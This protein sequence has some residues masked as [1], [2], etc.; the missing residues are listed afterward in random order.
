MSLPPRADRRLPVLEIGAGP[1]GPR[2]VVP[3]GYDDTQ[4][5]RWGFRQRRHG[6]HRKHPL[7]RREGK[8]IA[9]PFQYEDYQLEE[10]VLS[11]QSTL[12]GK[13]FPS[14]SHLPRSQKAVHLLPHP[15]EVHRFRQTGIGARFEQC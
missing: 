10:G 9:L 2:L 15:L 8:S 1:T 13:A 5:D 14:P 12:G 7:Y 6:D 11:V 4:G 3:S